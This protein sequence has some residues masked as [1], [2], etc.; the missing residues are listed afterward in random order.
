[1]RSEYSAHSLT[2][3]LFTHSVGAMCSLLALDKLVYP[4]DQVIEAEKRAKQLI[5]CNSCF[6]YC[7]KTVFIISAALLHFLLVTH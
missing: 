3:S 5:D 6:M 2:R 7:A 1:M 4:A